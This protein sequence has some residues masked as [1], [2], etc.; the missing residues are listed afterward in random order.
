MYRL[1]V[2]VGLSA[3][4]V[5]AQDS[6]KKKESA[7]SCYRLEEQKWREGADG[8]F[9]KYFRMETT[10]AEARMTCKAQ[11]GDLV[12][13]KTQATRNAINKMYSHYKG[14]LT[15]WLGINVKAAG[16]KGQPRTTAWL[17]GSPITKTWWFNLKAVQTALSGNGNVCVYRGIKGDHLWRNRACTAKGFILCQKKLN[18][19][20]DRCA[21][22]ATMLNQASKDIHIPSCA[23]DNSFLAKQC[24]VKQCW[25]VRK[26]GV[27]ITGSRKPKDVKL[28]CVA[29]RK[30]PGRMTD[31]E[32]KAKK[33]KNGYAPVCDATG[34]YSARQCVKVVANSNFCWCSQSDGTYI[35]KTLHSKTDPKAPICPSHRD[36]VYDCTKK[37]GT[38]PHPFDKTRFIYCFFNH[39]YACHC[40]SGVTYPNK[41]HSA[42]GVKN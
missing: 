38:Y 14:D 11:G 32:K 22:E 34:A 41:P 8:L 18:Y 24:G 6:K 33:G 4:A 31:C 39:A 37:T 42:C 26:D 7:P 28:D 17:D 10:Y 16:K 30:R 12:M 23:A 2:L 27:E 5:V 19:E 1:I 36:L 15:F 9:Y 35:P 20:C 13:E 21:A 40:P 3:L 25:C 29:F